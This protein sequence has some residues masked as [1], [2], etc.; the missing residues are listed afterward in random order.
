MAETH[1]NYSWNNRSSKSLASIWSNAD[2]TEKGRDYAFLLRCLK[3]AVEQCLCYDF[4]PEILVADA[5]GA[6]T[7]GFMRAFGYKSIDEYCKID[8]YCI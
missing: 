6:I 7:R 1:T 3:K 8:E 5:A 4:K 2:K